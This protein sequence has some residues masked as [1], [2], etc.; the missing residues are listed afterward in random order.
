MSIKKAL[1]TL[2]LALASVLAQGHPVEPCRA[3]LAQLA[4]DYRSCAVRQA[5]A[6]QCVAAERALTAHMARCRQAGFTERD[7]ESARQHG[8]D[9]VVGDLAQSPYQQQQQQQRAALAM[10]Q[11]NLRNFSD[12]FPEFDHISPRLRERFHTP[13]CPN[14]YQGDAGRWL[15][16][17]D[18]LL[19]R[20]PLAQESDAV[21]REYRFHFF[22]REH[23]QRCYPPD[24]ATLENVKLLN[25]PSQLLGELA[26][27][28]GQRVV[29]CDSA[30]CR[31]EQ[32]QLAARYQ[33]Y[34][35]LYREHRRL[36]FCVDARRQR[37]RWRSLKGRPPPAP[38]AGSDCPGDELHTRALNAAGLLREL[39]R[40]L[41][42]PASP[43][44]ENARAEGPK[45]E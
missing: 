9:Q 8:F 4:A 30:Q 12:F 44:P 23:P 35:A 15:Y 31:E 40:E 14:A 6:G 27:R 28:P 24:P 26:R 11:P 37:A 3:R 21:P 25:L 5:S 33:R 2:M 41:F 39:E 38:V 34:A 45:T 22:S 1:I 18:T 7:L 16:R 19:R 42:E 13:D 29:R 32:E 36:A 43:G 10:M 20:L 17:G